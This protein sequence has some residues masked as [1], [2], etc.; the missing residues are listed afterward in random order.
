MADTDWNALIQGLN[1]QIAQ[2]QQVVT[3]QQTQITLGE[4]T[5][6]QVQ[7][8]IN[9]WGLPAN[10]ISRKV[11]MLNDPGYNGQVPE[12]PLMLDTETTTSK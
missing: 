3:A 9:Q 7:M 5:M 1:D 4:K 11:Q 10:A 2:L 8:G 12:D 6:A